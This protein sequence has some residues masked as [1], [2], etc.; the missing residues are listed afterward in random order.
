MAEPNFNFIIDDI[1]KPD[2]L[3]IP[4][5]LDTELSKLVKMTPRKFGQAILDVFD[6]LGGIE[7][8][9][10][11]AQIDPRG[12]IELLKKVLP[13]TIQAEGLDGLTVLLR[14]QYGNT[15]EVNTLGRTSPVPAA[16]GDTP[17][18]GSGHPQI[19]TGGNPT[20]IVI[21]ETYE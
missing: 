18:L 17:A 16:S 1:T 11:Q 19:A 20:D 21:K 3:L 7:W 15:L 10:G 13:K 14:D 2:E 8:L 4:E 12:F 5:V 9:L 6:K